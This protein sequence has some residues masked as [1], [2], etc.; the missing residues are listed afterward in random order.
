MDELRASCCQESHARRGGRSNT[1]GPGLPPPRVVGVALTDPNASGLLER[2]RSPDP[3]VVAPA[4]VEAEKT[5][6]LEAAP[7]IAELLHSFDEA[8]RAS[9]AE[10]LGYVGLKAPS[11]YGEALLPL[12]G[13]PV[14]L[15]RSCAAESLGALAYEPA[16]PGLGRLLVADSDELVRTSAAEAL[17]AFDGTQILSLAQIAIDDPDPTVRAYAARVI[18]VRGDETFLPKLTARLEVEQ[19]LQPRAALLTA[20]YLLGSK[21]DLPPLLDLLSRADIEQSTVVLNAVWDI[22]AQAPEA[23]IIRDAVTIRQGLARVKDGNSL[24]SRHADKVLKELAKRLG[25]SP[26]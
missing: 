10:A 26:N 21:H 17:A 20:R 9:A 1:E 11:R 4:I 8:I 24:V 25:A 2:L 15:V 16:I 14:N 22:I 19:A 5:R 7:I 23:A 6:A 12:L 3:T 13:D 18:G